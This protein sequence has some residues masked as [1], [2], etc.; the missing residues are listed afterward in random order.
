[1]DLMSQKRSHLMS[2]VDLARPEL[3]AVRKA[4]DAAAAFV[5]FAA[6]PPRPRFRFEY[7][8]KPELLAFLREHYEGWRKFNTSEAERLCAMTIEQAK[9]PRALATIPALGQAWWATDDPKYGEAFQR[10]FSVPTGD[11]FNWENFNG[12]QPAIELDAFF[13]LL[14]CPGFSV[15]G[16]IAFLDHTHA[17]TDNAW[18]VYT[19]RWNQLMLG[20]EGHNWY[21]HGM[22]ALPMFGLLFP[23]FKR[24]AFFLRTGWSVVEEHVR[25]HYKADGGARET[26]LGYQAGSMRNLWDMYAIA[27]RNGY[28]MSPGFVD[29]LLNATLFLL[30][31]M[32]P[33]GGLPS[34]GDGGHS[35][36][37]M[38]DL[39][40][41]AAALTG[42][43]RCKWYA[44]YC[45]ARLEAARAK[46]SSSPSQAP[47]VLPL[48]SF[49]NVGLTGARTYA[50]TRARNPNH[51]SVLM[52]PTGYAALRSS[53][54]PDA[55][56]LAVAA[57]DRGPIVTSHGH[58]DVFALDVLAS[59]VR[60][61]GEMGCA[62]Y[63]NTPGRDYDQKTEAHNCLT[64]E[65]M[66]QAPIINEWR[67]SGHAIPAVRRWITEPTH[68]FFHG[69]HEGFYNWSKH[70]TLHARKVFF[71][72]SEPSYWVVFDWV[73]SNIKN[74]YRIYFHGCVPG[75]LEG[76]AIMLGEAKGPRLAVMPP[77]E[78]RLAVRKVAP[79]GLKAYIREKD[80]DAKSYPCF[81]Y[82]RKA[83]SHCFVWALMPLAPR[84]PLP[85]VQRLPE[86]VNGIA[87][88]AHGA[89]AVQIAFRGV[90]DTLCVS[91]K[92]F[93]G[94]LEFGGQ[95]S[96]GNLAFR[97]SARGKGE[98]LAID[99]T[100]ADG[101]CGR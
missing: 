26:T 71:V 82:A 3:A 76:Q 36:G 12:T 16:R 43:G 42:D 95:R 30:R 91:H 4:P 72:K 73:E 40:A 60:F 92:D 41:T 25:G 94:D 32:S 66:E 57:A 79:E 49:W 27:Q 85:Q 13:L 5:A 14:D 54:A 68:D 35:L 7:E 33:Q 86:V 1:M 63:G 45:Q 31:L 59:G 96:W 9:G 87:E 84:E 15:E 2:Y 11:M 48:C 22:H 83:E 77:A 101:V 78:D 17:I 89:T 62:P 20:P 8:C 93:D 56:Y 64:I 67:W 46:P 6:R 47:G 55:N 51:V 37:G 44:E 21:L 65:G 10:F 50:A 99:H 61:L 75:K 38:T 34:F 18:D 81:A 19:S 80:L 70:L 28:P 100:M 69:V 24:S 58:N 74:D 23:E 29:R 98:I 90:T 39:A 88:D 97:R 53:D 52:G